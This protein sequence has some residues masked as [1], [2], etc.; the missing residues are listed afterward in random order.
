MLIATRLLGCTAPGNSSV[1]APS[2]LCET[3]FFKPAGWQ[4]GMS[5]NHVPR[6]KCAFSF[7]MYGSVMQEATNG[8]CAR[9]VNTG[10]CSCPQGTGVMSHHIVCWPAR[11]ASFWRDLVSCSR[12]NSICLREM[13]LDADCL[14]HN[15]VKNLPCVMDMRC[16]LE[17]HQASG[18]TDLP[19][20]DYMP[21]EHRD[22]LAC[23]PQQ[24]FAVSVGGNDMREVNQ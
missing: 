19:C 24:C 18:C 11:N 12:L 15:F 10:R 22:L 5:A 21:W 4:V 23:C 2:I 20:T 17:S 3:C 9:H 14:I 6:A 1:L 7:L 16:L 13:A 8:W